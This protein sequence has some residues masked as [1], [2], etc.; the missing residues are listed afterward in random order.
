MNCLN[1]VKKIIDSYN[2]EPIKLP[3][4]FKNIYQLIDHVPEIKENFKSEKDDM[5]LINKYREYIS[6]GHYGFS[7]GTPTNPKWNDL[8]DKIL[9]YFISI[10]PTFEIQQIKIKFG[11]MCFYVTSNVIEDIQDIEVL[12]MRT[13]SDKSLIY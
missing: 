13:L 9:E 5:F 1:D 4:G 7:I 12:I 6:K 11:F 10:D 3:E 2:L 8:I